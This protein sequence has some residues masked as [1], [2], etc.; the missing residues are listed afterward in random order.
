[1]TE[2]L[3]AIRGNGAIRGDE[4]DL[5]ALGVPQG[6]STMVAARVAQLE[7][8]HQA[9][10][11]TAAVIGQRFDLPLLCAVVGD[12]DLVL[13][14][15][16]DAEAAGL[17]GTHE[18]LG[19]RQFAHALI[20]DALYRGLTPSERIR[21]H[22][23][24]LGA[25]DALPGGERRLGELA[26]HATQAAPLVGVDVAVRSR[27]RAADRAREDLAFEEAASHHRAALDLLEAAGLADT[28]ESCDLRIDL[29]E[30]LHRAGDVVAGEAALLAA[31][32]GA[33]RLDDP[34]R[35]ARAALA[36]PAPGTGPW[37]LGPDP[38]P[39]LGVVEDALARTDPEDSTSR[40]RLL[41]VQATRTGLLVDSAAS[42]RRGQTAAAEAIAM[43]R[44][45]GHD[46]TLAKVLVGAYTPYS[47]PDNLGER[48]GLCDEM[49]TISDRVHDLESA[50]R[51]RTHRATCRI[52]AGDLDGARADLD[53]AERLLDALRQPIHAF[54]ATWYGACLALLEGRLDDAERRIEAMPTYLRRSGEGSRRDPHRR[55]ADR[56][57]LDARPSRRDRR[58][59]PRRGRRRRRPS[60]ESRA[61]EAFVLAETGATDRARRILD[62]LLADDVLSWVTHSWMGLTALSVLATVT[63]ATDH[64]EA[65]RRLEQALAALR[66]PHRHQRLGG[67][68]PPVALVLAD[69]AATQGRTGDADRHYRAAATFCQDKGLA[70][71]S[72]I[73]SVGW[74]EML[75]RTGDPADR[76][77]AADLAGHALVIA[78]ELGMAREIERA[79]S[80]LAR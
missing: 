52:E 45:L 7:P 29:T 34:A 59:R 65:A 56:P 4:I 12:D 23:D 27:R 9:V 78:E 32:D 48:V 55:D 26:H 71:Y 38:D 51:A 5:A 3:H 6:A 43:A 63:V 37:W 77:H 11:R 17:V 24:V 79:R 75:T 36:G 16:A 62:D 61:M 64:R 76:P 74:A 53:D 49:V 66:R 40:A 44:R 35:L 21:Q 47:T 70:G 30:A 60:H 50:Q 72:A 69:L 2:I 58:H 10:L 25:L 33:R 41:A 20:R 80:L 22:R 28:G 54:Y 39:C 68:G 67:P 13:G 8:T 73:T 57:V 15:L 19:G 14:A 18:V 46:P 1:M 31:A 42:V